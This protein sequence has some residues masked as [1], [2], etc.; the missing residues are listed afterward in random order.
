MSL[1]DK[2]SYVL[3]MRVRKSF[4][5]E[6]KRLGKVNFKRGYYIYVGSS[7]LRTVNSRILR[8]MRRKKRLFWHIDF[9]TSSK[10]CK[11]REIYVFRYRECSL[12][13]ALVRE[14]FRV[15]REKF[16]SSDCN[17]PSHLFYS[18][19]RRD[20]QKFLNRPQCTLTKTLCI[21]VRILS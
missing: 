7:P 1:K 10:L 3:F 17:C 2:V 12:A 21:S 5:C 8:H 13:H 18:I 11:I 16:G 9:L 20:F 6:V 14:G 19:R 4:F 15:A